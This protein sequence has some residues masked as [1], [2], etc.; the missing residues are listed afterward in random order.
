[1][2]NSSICTGSYHVCSSGPHARCTG[3]YFPAIMLLSK[4]TGCMTHSLLI[5]SLKY[6]ELSGILIQ[7]FSKPH[8]DSMSED[9][10]NPL[11]KL[12]LFSVKRN[13]LLIKELYQSLRRSQSNSFF[14]PHSPLYDHISVFFLLFFN[15]CLDLICSWQFFG[16]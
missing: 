10:E 2:V 14:H 8:S 16:A 5:S 7:C 11:Y 12:C 15:K 3:N 1:M 6:F 9:S 4:S 13:I